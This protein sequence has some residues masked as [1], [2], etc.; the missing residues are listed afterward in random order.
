MRGVVL[1]TYL[2]T[3][4]QHPGYVPAVAAVGPVVAGVQV[5]SV[6][7]QY[8]PG[9]LK[10]ALCDVLPYSGKYRAPPMR[11]VPVVQNGGWGRSDVAG[12][13]TP[14]GSTVAAAYP[15]AAAPLVN[16][17]DL[18]GDVVLIGF[19]EDDLQQPIILGRFHH[20]NAEEPL[21][22]WRAR[23][24]L[25]GPASVQVT[26]HRG[27]RAA[28]DSDGNYTLDTSGASSGAV[29]A[30]G[31]ELP[32]LEGDITFRGKASRRIELL[33]APVHLRG[34]T[35]QVA[36]KTDT[37]NTAC[38]AADVAYWITALCTMLNGAGVPPPPGHLTWAAFATSLTTTGLPGTITSGNPAVLTDG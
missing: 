11:L 28:T 20:Q 2:P 36:R 13:W 27:T 35:R 3:D 10:A 15:T 24:P 22:T 12:G 32:G 38:S 16:P 25:L 33:D 19:V 31:A 14:R 4:P 5:P 8:T 7:R 21:P 18:D 26:R 29:D 17:A 37:T 6:Y 34:T 23:T 30:Y 1:R 9:M